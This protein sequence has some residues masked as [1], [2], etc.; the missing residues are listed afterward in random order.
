MNYIN[1]I[2]SWFEK[3]TEGWIFGTKD[4]KLT[5]KGNVELE[6][7]AGDYEHTFQNK[8]GVVAHLDDIPGVSSWQDTIDV[9]KNADRA[10]LYHDV[11]EK[12]YFAG[13]AGASPTVTIQDP[14]TDRIYVYGYFLTYGGVT[15]NHIMAL[16]PDGTI[17]STYVTGTGFNNFTYLSTKI[18]LQSDGKII[19]PGAFTNYNGNAIN[20]IVRINTDGSIDN[21]FSIGTGFNSW[22]LQAVEDSLG[23]IYVTGNF[24]T[25]NGISGLGR[26]IRLNADGTRDTSFVT[27]AGFNNVT[28]SALPDSSNN[29]YITG[30]FST[31]KGVAVSPRIVKLLANGDVDATFNAGT[32]F[33]STSGQ[34]LKIYHTSDGKLMVV[35]YFTLYNGTTIN[36]IVKLNLNGTVDTSFQSQGTG[37]NGTFVSE[38]TEYDGNYLFSGNFTQYNGT[39]SNGTVLLSSTGELVRAFPESAYYNTVLN[40]GRLLLSGK[41]GSDYFI[42]IAEDNY[43]VNV[44]E[45][46]YSEV[47]GKARYKVGGLSTIEDEEIMPRR[48]IEELIQETAIPPTPTTRYVT[49]FVATEGQVLFTVIQPLPVGYFDV[50][51]NGVK[52][53]SFTSTDFTV[54][55]DEGSIAGDIIDIVSYNVLSLTSRDTR[56]NATDSVDVNTNYCGV[57]PANSLETDEVWTIY[58]IVVAND[59][60][61]TTT[62]AIDVAWTDREI[63]IYT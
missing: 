50:F 23:K 49:T 22:T 8:D 24:G 1:A 2:G 52:I 18:L 25:Y 55:L 6:G 56:R 19:Y 21:T 16:N 5:F 13:Y 4:N 38:F 34:L 59:G 20:R 42:G 39:T 29:V 27:G 43:I 10:R 32:G 3:I 9:D 61:V 12:E 60:S 44:K 62:S 47:D 35:G 36:K 7:G 41:D 48:L 46:D 54:T 17:D 51:L 57:A 15:K 45:F 11:F 33:N 53:N 58:K 14:T 40:D 28:I 26:I 31:Y 63:I 37:L 30:Y